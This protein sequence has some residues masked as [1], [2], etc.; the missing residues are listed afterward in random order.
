MLNAV[1]TVFFYYFLSLHK[2]IIHNK[3]EQTNCNEISLHQEFVRL[4]I[5]TMLCKFMHIYVTCAAPFCAFR[6]HT[7]IYMYA[8]NIMCIPLAGNFKSCCQ[9]INWS[10]YRINATRDMCNLLKD[11]AAKVDGRLLQCE[12]ITAFIYSTYLQL[13]SYIAYIKYFHM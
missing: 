8:F 11:Y 9:S 2:S 13:S 10:V 7:H 4:C 12:I 5:G 1:I 6:I 3:L